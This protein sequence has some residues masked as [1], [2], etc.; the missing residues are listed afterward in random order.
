MNIGHTSLPSVS[1][2][3]LQDVIA[4]EYKSKNDLHLGG[5]HS[6]LRTEKPGTT[7]VCQFLDF[8]GAFLQ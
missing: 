4:D 5:A 2:H 6:E 1:L 7:S 8:I 3:Y